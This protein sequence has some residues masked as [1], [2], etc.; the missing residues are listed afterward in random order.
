MLLGRKRTFHEI[1]GHVLFD[2][3]GHVLFL[4]SFFLTFPQGF[5]LRV[6]TQFTHCPDRLG[7]NVPLVPP[8]SSQAT[9]REEGLCDLQY[10]YSCNKYSVL[11]Y[12]YIYILMYLLNHSNIHFVATHF[13]GKN[14]Y[15][16]C[17]I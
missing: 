9:V 13:S 15:E 1:Y 11:V 2:I 3:Y 8:V 10:L 14:G 12:I 5:G 4:I 7:C 6:L 16:W 17:Q